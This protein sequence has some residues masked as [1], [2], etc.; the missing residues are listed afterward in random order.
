M[1]FKFLPSIYLG[2]GLGANDAANVFGPQVNSGTIK[3][4]K[5]TI[6]TAIFILIGA[7]L[8]GRKAFITIGGI[9]DLVLFS[10]IISALTAALAVNIMSHL[11]L[12]VSTSQAVVG[13]IVGLS[14][15]RGSPVDYVK[16]AK[17]LVCWFL[18]PIG[19]AAVAFVSYHLL[20]MVW[21]KR[22]TNLVTFNSTVRVLSIIFG[23]YAAYSLG[24]NNVANVMGA[25][26]AAKAIS[27]FLATILGGVSIA[28]G[29]LTYSRNVM[30]T[31]GKKITP[32]D[33]FSALIAVL[34]EAVALHTFA[35]IGVPVSSSQ[36]VVGAVVGVGLVKGTGMIN[37]TTLVTILVGWVVTLLGSAAVA[38]SLGWVI[39]HFV[40]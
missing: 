11:G 1:V 23:C 17:I 8:E 35:Q 9:S 36:A 33:P 32:L 2:W 25:F 4:R 16:L 30:Y 27:P 14:L 10:A 31:V 5:A 13:S 15:L 34:A 7:V 12:P 38:Y 29:V 21:R 3:Y 37:R 24:A 40:A 39:Q 20:A 6:L 18:T 22:A 19:G 28:A 26:V